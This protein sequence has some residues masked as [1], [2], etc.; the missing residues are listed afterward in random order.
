MTSKLYQRVFFKSRGLLVYHSL[1]INLR[2]ASCVARWQVE[3][4][5]SQLWASIANT[6]KIA[7]LQCKNSISPSPCLHSTAL[8]FSVNN[9]NNNNNVDIGARYGFEPIAVET[10]GRIPSI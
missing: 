6:A 8:C 10:L 9:N 4:D 1:F 3:R 5:R 2:A 7:R